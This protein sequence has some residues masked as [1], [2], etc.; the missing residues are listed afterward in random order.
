[1]QKN[2]SQIPIAI[3]GAG[4]AGMVAALALAKNNHACVL[5]GQEPNNND[6]RTTALMMPAIEIL[7]DLQIWDNLETKATPLSV[8][9]IIDGTKRLVRSPVV[10]FRAHEINKPAFGYNIQNNDLNEALL[11]SIK[12]NP[13]I[14]QIFSSVVTYDHH[15]LNVY[16]TLENGTLLKSALLVAADGRASLARKAAHI[17]TQEWTYPQT[18]ITL[19]FSHDIPHANISTEFH[20]EDGPFT[21]V[22]LKGNH[23]SLVWVTNPEYAKYLLS[24][25]IKELSIIVEEKMHSMIGRIQITTSPQTWPLSGLIPQQFA[26]KR[27]ILVGESAHVFPPIGAQGLNLGIRDALCLTQSI[28]HNISDPGHKNVLSNY[29]RLRKPDI[30]ARTGSVHALNYALLSDFLPAQLLRSTGLE[31]LKKI[32][33]LRRFFMYEGMHPGHG[34]QDA[35]KTLI[36]LFKNPSFNNFTKT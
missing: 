31:M 26:A 15:D 24:L 13:L 9:R 11:K 29:N 19:S 7:K 28:Q 20:T 27:T 36:E 34:F 21:Q 4:P 16:I 6:G 12:K 33:P 2:I 32:S 5:I 35:T 10:N 18:A 8:M 23:S 1:M 17:Q 14:T 30:W 3:V 22:P 25:S